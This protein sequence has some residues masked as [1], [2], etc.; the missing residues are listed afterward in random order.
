MVLENARH[1]HRSVIKPCILTTL[2]VVALLGARL[3]LSYY[4]TKNDTRLLWQQLSKHLPQGAYKIV[5]VDEQAYGLLFYGAM[6]VENVAMSD[7]P[8]PTFS[9]PERFGE[10]LKDVGKDK[11]HF[12]FVFENQGDLAEAEKQMRETG[13]VCDKRLL[14]FQR[15]VLIHKL[16]DSKM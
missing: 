6:E 9:V 11:H 14:Q 15:S 10:E 7:R 8:Y 3:A 13:V 16:Q 12:V 5:T 4:P 1:G 2:W